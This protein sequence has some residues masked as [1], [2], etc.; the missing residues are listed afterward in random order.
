MYGD[1]HRSLDHWFPCAERVLS[2]AEIPAQACSHLHSSKALLLLLL[3]FQLSFYLNVG[4]GDKI[5]WGSKHG[6]HADNAHA[7]PFKSKA[8]HQASPSCSSDAGSCANVAGFSADTSTKDSSGLSPVSL[9]GG[10]ISCLK[11]GTGAWELL[12]GVTQQDSKVQSAALWWE[13]EI[14]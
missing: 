2:H 4:R 12:R 1:C 11:Y 6:L 7:L 8:L 10:T 3:L 13:L 5:C 9:T 14:K